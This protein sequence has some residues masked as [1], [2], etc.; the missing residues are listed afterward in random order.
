[1][2]LLP[3]T[4]RLLQSPFR[5]TTKA[6]EFQEL[7]DTIQAINT[8]LDSEIEKKNMYR[9]E[10]MKLKE[11]IARMR[12]EDPTFVLPIAI[13][14]GFHFDHEATQNTQVEFCKWNEDVTKQADD[15]LT[16][17]VQA[18]DKTSMLT[19]KIQDLEGVWNDFQPI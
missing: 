7:N 8:R 4:I 1:M 16:Q 9:E 19:F 14:H 10:N 11:Y 18:F 6:H 15:F 5:Q 13:D 2:W 3:W 17:F 12:H